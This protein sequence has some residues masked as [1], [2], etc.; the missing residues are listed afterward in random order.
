MRNI[1]KEIFIINNNRIDNNF[2]SNHFLISAYIMNSITISSKLNIIIAYMLING[3]KIFLQPLALEI[4]R[5][6]YKYKHILF[7]N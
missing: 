5:V 3:I 2:V 6:I 4:L 1:A 7:V